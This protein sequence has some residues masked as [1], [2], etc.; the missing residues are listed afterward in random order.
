MRDPKTHAKTLALRSQAAGRAWED[1]L[2]QDDQRRCRHIEMLIS[3]LEKLSVLN[4]I[5]TGWEYIVEDDGTAY[6]KHL[7]YV[8][9]TEEEA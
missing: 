9:D 4:Y 6:W 3:R 2:D 1:A 7:E 5:S 8:P